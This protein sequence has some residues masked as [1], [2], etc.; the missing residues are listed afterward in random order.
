MDV[1]FINPFLE[2]TIEVLTK[3]AFVNPKHGK[4]YLKKTI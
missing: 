2:G 3:M 4:P 1:K